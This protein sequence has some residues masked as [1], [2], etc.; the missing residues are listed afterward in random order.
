[1]RDS[2]RQYGLLALKILAGLAFLA[3]GTAK[4]AGAGMMVDTF[5]AL[6]LGQWFRYVT[7]VIEIAGAIL[8]FVPGRQAYGGAILTVTMVGASLAH[9]VVLGADTMLPAILL[10]AIT[11]VVTWAHREQLPWIGASGHA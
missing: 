11:A 8:L 1:M 10:G 5:Q 3:A 2:V 4:L 9:M 7:G 6:G